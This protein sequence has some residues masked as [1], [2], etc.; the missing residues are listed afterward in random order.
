[1][2]VDSSDN[3]FSLAMADGADHAGVRIADGET[4]TIT[5]GNG[6]NT[7]TGGTGVETFSVAAAELTSADSLTGAAGSDIL[8]LSSDAAIATGDLANLSGIDV[9]NLGVSNSTGIALSDVFVNASDSDTVA[10][11]ATGAATLTDLDTSDVAAARS[12]VIATGNAVSLVDGANSTVTA[13]AGVD[14]SIAGGSG[15]DTVKSTEAGFTAGD[16]INGGTGADVLNITDASNITSAELANVTNVETL[17]LDGATNT[18]VLNEAFIDAQ[19]GAGADNAGDITIDYGSNALSLDA[20]AATGTETVTLNGSGAVTL[21][22]GADLLVADQAVDYNITAAAGSN[23]IDVDSGANL[24]GNDTITTTAGASDVLLFGSATGAINFGTI[25]GVTGFE[26]LSFGATGNGTITLTDTLVDSTAADTLTVTTAAAGHTLTLDTSAVNVARTVQIADGVITL[27]ANDDR[28]VVTDAAPSINGGNGEDRIIFTEADDLATGDSINGGGDTD[29]IIVTTDTT[30][31][32]NIANGNDLNDVAGVEFLALTGGAGTEDVA[33]TIT[34]DGTSEI[35]FLV[36]DGTMALTSTATA[37]DVTVMSSGLVT[38]TDGDA[39]TLADVSGTV[40]HTANDAWGASSEIGTLITNYTGG[41]ATLAGAA[42]TVIGGSGADSINAVAGTAATIS[43]EGGT[44]ADTITI[45]TDSFADATVIKGGSDTDTIVFTNAVDVTGDAAADANKDSIEVLKLGANANTIVLAAGEADNISDSGT[46]ALT[47]NTDGYTITSLELADGLVTLTG[48]DNTGTANVTATLT[49]GASDFTVNGI[50]T[51]TLFTG[52]NHDITGGA[53]SVNGGVDTWSI[54]E[55]DFEGTDTLDGGFGSDILIVN[56]SGG[57]GTDVVDAD[58]TNVS[59][60]ETVRLGTV[61]GGQT[62]SFVFGNNADT[63]IGAG[64]SLTFDING[65]EQAGLTV[66]TS[67]LD[68]N[69]TLI[70]QD[71]GGTA[72]V[73]LLNGSAVSIADGTDGSI[74]GSASADSITGGN[75]ADT[76][77]GGADADT[78]TGGAGNDSLTGGDGN[79]FFVFA[80]ASDTKITDMDDGAGTDRIVLSDAAFTFTSDEGTKSGGALTDNVDIYDTGSNFSAGDQSATTATFIYDRTDG[81]LYY[82][83]DGAG[84]GTAVLIATI[85]NYFGG[86]FGGNNYVY[87]ASDFIGGA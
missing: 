81:E 82:D 50:S 26:T 43:V 80:E 54:L 57:D 60:I 16:S 25:S 73:T 1:M 13:L 2:T 83:A 29:A 75:G 36:N 44:G 15:N 61:S 79:D 85:Q 33:S 22:A 51:L 55:T 28:V 62:S 41:S 66:D 14:V 24:D 9:L 18:V 5:L 49:G 35:N 84:G 69:R 34:V 17:D 71:N 65:Q 78:L 3:T 21:T 27:G 31:A 59:N 63:A 52:A 48:G 77:S 67:D 32:L 8:N 68:A 86:G 70:L 6:A 46:G 64:N 56:E 47:I 4:A 76:F 74:T 40:A 38:V 53:T 37:G 12:V 87:D 7:I 30:V 10:I 58:F 39:V 72:T 19:D 23:S 20:S 42:G 45:D 11:T